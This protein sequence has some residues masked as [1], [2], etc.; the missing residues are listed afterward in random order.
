M[1]VWVR[2]LTS[3][4]CAWPPPRAQQGR[5]VGPSLGRRGEHLRRAGKEETW[6]APGALAGL[7]GYLGQP[8]RCNIDEGCKPQ[9]SPSRGKDWG[10]SDNDDGA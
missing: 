7:K 5:C 3:Q 10:P 2:N 4:G 6:G 1:G 8:S 9:H